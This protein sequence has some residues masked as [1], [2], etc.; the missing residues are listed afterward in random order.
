MFHFKPEKL[1]IQEPFSTGRNM[2]IYPYQSDPTDQR[3]MVRMINLKTVEEVQCY[4]DEIMPSIDYIHPFIHTIIGS[5]I[6]ANKL[7]DSIIIHLKIPRITSNLK[8]FI[9]NL[10]GP[11]ETLLPS[12][13]EVI[14]WFYSICS[15]LDYLESK[16]VTHG[17]LKPE[18]LVFDNKGDLLLSE[19]GF[20]QLGFDESWVLRRV[21]ERYTAP[22]CQDPEFYKNPLEKNDVFQADAWSLGM[23]MLDLCLGRDDT[24]SSNKKELKPFSDDI[25]GSI[26]QIKEKYSAELSEILAE[27]LKLDPLSRAN[28]KDTCR[29]LEEKFPDKYHGK[30]KI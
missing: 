25:Q 18:N 8:T 19:I 14:P 17:N 6:Q 7:D 29:A 9:R 27:L 20:C 11:Y 21:K 2:T 23:I 1:N 26:L 15:A 3:W 22:E 24:K 10:K 30:T 16:G 5:H 4:N 28:F 13:E 12:M